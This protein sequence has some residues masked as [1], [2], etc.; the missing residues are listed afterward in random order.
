M[1]QNSHKYGG[2][3]LGHDRDELHLPRLHPA[4]V[5]YLSITKRDQ[6]PTRRRRRRPGVKSDGREHHAHLPH[7]GPP[8]EAA[9]EE[10]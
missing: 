9:G 6:T 4:L 7:V 2:L 8:L 10:A 3:G 1:S 5:T